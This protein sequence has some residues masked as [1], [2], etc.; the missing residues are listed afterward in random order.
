[1]ERLGLSLL[2]C[3]DPERA[4]RLALRLLGAG[5]A[6]GSGSFTT[7]RLRTQLA[8][9][10]LPNPVGASAGF[11]KNAVA[12]PAT[13]RTGFGFCEI[14]AV[15]PRPQEGNPKPRLFRLSEDKA[16]INRFGFNNA[17]MDLIHANL[18]RTPRPGIVGVNLGANKDTEDKAEDYIKVLSRFH[19]DVSFATVNV[20][21]PNTERLR[22][23]QGRA[24]LDALLAR[25]LDAR[26][27]LGPLPVFLKIAPDLEASEITDIAEVCL[28]RGI[29]AIIATNTTLSRDGLRSAQASQAGGMSGAPL[30]ERSTAVLRQLRKATGGQIPLIGVGGIGSAEQAYAKIRAG[31]AAVQLYSAMVYQGVSLGRRIAE[32][33]DLLLAKGGFANVAEAVGTED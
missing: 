13:L 7:P 4:H 24:A 14:G 16:V 26:D 8:G 33:L 6:G 30:F 2:H 32:G 25:V 31:A 19:A 15:T 11:D 9:L 1:M 17:G 28:A 22:D 23:L 29:D 27:A 5:L 20:S 10:D 3:M 18:T 12:V 21:S